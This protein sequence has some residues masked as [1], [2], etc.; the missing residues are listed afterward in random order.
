MSSLLPIN[1][2]AQDE[3]LLSALLVRGTS[4]SEGTGEPLELSLELAFTS[5]AVNPRA[6]AREKECLAS[7]ANEGTIFE[8][9]APLLISRLLGRMFLPLPASGGQSSES[10][11]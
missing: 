2:E 7:T 10:E 4:V 6:R 8:G 5:L 1:W 9:M 11:L 3:S